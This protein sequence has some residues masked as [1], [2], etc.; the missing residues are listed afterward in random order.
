MTP[1]RTYTQ[2]LSSIETHQE[3]TSTHLRNIDAHMA[4][5]NDKLY[6]LEKS[7]TENKNNIKWIVGIGGGIITLILIPVVLNLIGVI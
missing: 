4:R 2:V 5:Q 1:K 6:E 7:N 3:Y